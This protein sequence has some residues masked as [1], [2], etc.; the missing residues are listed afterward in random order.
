MFDN[1]FPFKIFYQIANKV[2]FK[3]LQSLILTKVCSMSYLKKLTFSKLLNY[4]KIYNTF[5]KFKELFSE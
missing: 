5:F 3:L 2:Y 1:I 4:L